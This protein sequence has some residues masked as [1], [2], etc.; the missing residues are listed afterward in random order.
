M[1]SR[2]LLRNLPVLELDVKLK[3]FYGYYYEN[4]QCLTIARGPTV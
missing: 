1:L 2:D 4:L 3:V